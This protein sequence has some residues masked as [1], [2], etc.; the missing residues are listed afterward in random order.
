LS[1]SNKSSGEPDSSS[2]VENFQSLILDKLLT[3]YLPQSQIMNLK[4]LYISSPVS[5]LKLFSDT[6]ANEFFYKFLSK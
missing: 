3:K 1:I 2:Q 5:E 6:A 4:K